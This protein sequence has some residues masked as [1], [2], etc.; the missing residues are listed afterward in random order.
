[1]EPVISTQATAFLAGHR[2]AVVGASDRQG[3]FGVTI[4]KELADHGHDVV[5]VNA[6][7]PTVGG[8]TCYPTLAEVPG[9]LDG[10]VVMVGPERV[11][12]VV[13]QCIELSIHH[14]WLFKGIGGAGSV[15]PDAVAR[16]RDNGIEVVAGACPLMFLEPVGLIHRIHRSARRANHSLAP[17]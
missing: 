2:L 11:A 3:N 15:T 17:A 8:R 1:M 10:V 16:C 12:D 13:R 5:P 4:L 6:H 14:V 9:T 7:A